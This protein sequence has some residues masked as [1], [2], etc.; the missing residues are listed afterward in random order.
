MLDKEAELHVE[1]ATRVQKAS[2]SHR[3]SV[4]ILDNDIVALQSLMD[5]LPTYPFIHELV[6]KQMK[7]SNE[8]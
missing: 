6:L 7:L 8:S 1:N 3:L 5:L 2:R 4:S